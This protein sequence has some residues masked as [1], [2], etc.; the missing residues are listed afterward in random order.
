MH[1]KQLHTRYIQYIHM[2]WANTLCELHVCVCI[3]MYMCMYD[4]CISMHVCMY[5]YVLYDRVCMSWLLVTNLAATN[6]YNMHNICNDSIFFRQRFSHYRHKRHSFASPPFFPP[7]SM[8]CFP[9]EQAL[10]R[11]GIFI[12]TNRAEIQPHNHSRDQ[13]RTDQTYNFPGEC[14]DMGQ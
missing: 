3:A 14:R 13:S 12:L 4:V 6:T 2:H 5:L 8:F 9:T 7:A 11:V 1:W 10:L